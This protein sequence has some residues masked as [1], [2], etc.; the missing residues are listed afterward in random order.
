MAKNTS[1]VMVDFAENYSFHIQDE[2]QSSTNGPTNVVLFIRWFVI[3]RVKK[4]NLYMPVFVFC[5][6]KCNTMLSV[7]Q[8]DVLH[9]TKAVKSIYSSC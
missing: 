6:K 4:V 5:L 7:S 2:A 9:N 3:S 1:L 8:I